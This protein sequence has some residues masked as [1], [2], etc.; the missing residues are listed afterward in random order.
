MITFQIELLEDIKEEMIPILVEHNEEVFGIPEFDLSPRW[1]TYEEM[2]DAGSF[3]IFTARD[4]GE[5]VGYVCYFLTNHLH[6]SD[7]VFA[8]QDNV[9]IDKRYRGSGTFGD[10]LEFCE[11]NL[12]DLGADVI[13]LS[14]KGRYNPD[15]LAESLGYFKEEHLFLKQLENF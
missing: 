11:R 15:H 9:Y 14:L 12:R 10:L 4:R 8:N 7:K 6:Y 3:Y 13:T 1:D 5:L 2:E